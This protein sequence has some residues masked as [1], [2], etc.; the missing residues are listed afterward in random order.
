MKFLSVLFFLALAFGQSTAYH[1]AVGAYESGNFEGAES[2]FEQL[3]TSSDKYQAH[4]MLMMSQYAQKRYQSVKKTYSNLMQLN[5]SAEYLDDAYYLYGKALFQQNEHQKAVELWLMSLNETNDK[6]LI[7]KLHRLITESLEKVSTFEDITDYIKTINGERAQAVLA[8]K[9]AEIEEKNGR[10]LNARSYLT[11]F[12]R[13]YPTSS[14]TSVANQKV[15][16][17]NKKISDHVYIGVLLPFEDS[18]EFS[19]A[20]YSGYEFAVKEMR[21]KLGIDISLKKE[22]C[23]TTVLSAIHAA[24]RLTDDRSIIAVVGPLYS[25]QSAAVALLANQSRVPVITPTAALHGLVDL[26]KF[27]YQL[28]SDNHTFGKLVAEYAFGI[29]N[30]RSFA[31]LSAESGKSY[32]MAQGFRETVERLGGEIVDSEIYYATK[33]NNLRDQFSAIH[34]AG[35]KKVFRD[36]LEGVN[37]AIETFTI[38]TMYA[39]RLLKTKMREKLTGYEVD[40]SKILV[41]SID[42]IFMPIEIS[43]NEKIVEYIARF[44][45]TNAFDT[46][47]LGT[48]DWYNPELFSN[49]NLAKAFDSLFVFMPFHVD[50]N[51]T[52]TRAF[53]NKYR[54]QQQKTPE[55]FDYLGYR[56]MRF[57]LAGLSK[58]E[59]T[60]E[61][62]QRQLSNENDLVLIGGQI[63][64]NHKERV[65]SGTKVLQ[66]IRAHFKDISYK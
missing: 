12:A 54:T 62:V 15:E 63:D 3:L 16:K 14:Y 52:E 39:T 33:V 61:T 36:S 2:Q 8:I 57:V 41:S 38:D 28:S 19:N 48:S 66:L 6:L 25:D 50:E 27:F 13:N 31:I 55:Y 1:L 32:E 37:P 51:A 26:S 43:D 30:Q 58:T 29:L 10:F 35:I 21:D 9:A 64:F 49:P 5:P 47:V 40:S 23:G 53:I 24:Q 56:T 20:L 22:D 7:Q 4:V 59:N 17:L 60:R 65:N 11:D 18:P 42:A 46:H 45:A 44:Y 34:R